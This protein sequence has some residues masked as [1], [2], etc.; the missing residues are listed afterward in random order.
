[1]PLFSHWF[2]ASPSTP[3]PCCAPDLLLQVKYYLIFYYSDCVLFCNLIS[4]YWYYLVR[5]CFHTSVL[6]LRF[7]LV[8]GPFLESLLNLSQYCFCFMFWGFFFF[9]PWGMWDLSSPT[10]D[11]THIPCT[12]R[13]GSLNHWAN[14]EVPSPV[15]W[16]WFPLVL[17]R[18]FK[19]ADVKSWYS[20]SNVLASLVM[21][22]IDLYFCVW[23]IFPC[24]LARLMIFL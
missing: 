3:P 6:S 17:L 1:M 24:F 19:I 18:I 22:Y 23:A 8:C 14:R 4:G 7:F 15:L 16:T 21:V 5:H 9:C 11:Q 10:R 2:P 13:Q 12:Q 20:K